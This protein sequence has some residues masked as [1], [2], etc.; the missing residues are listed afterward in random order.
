MNK[1]KV[2]KR[3]YI[4]IYIYNT[5]KLLKSTFVETQHHGD[6]FRKF[7]LDMILLSIS[8]LLF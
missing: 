7:Y 4:Y 8:L 3:G 2:N 6:M 1:R 5:F